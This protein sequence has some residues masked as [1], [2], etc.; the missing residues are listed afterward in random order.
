HDAVEWEL[1][2][3]NPRLA[4]LPR[5][6]ALSKADLVDEDTRRRLRRQWAERLG[7]E[8]PVL[9]TSAVTGLG[10]HKLAGELL[11]MVPEEQGDVPRPQLREAREPMTEHR[12]FRPA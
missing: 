1:A 9:V 10:L 12:V 6:L 3:H 4:Q 5:V 7:P 2:Q 8:V 11:R